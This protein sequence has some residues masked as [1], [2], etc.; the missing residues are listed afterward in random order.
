MYNG[1][2]ND[3]V[4]WR[5]FGPKFPLIVLYRVGHVVAFIGEMYGVLSWK[6]LACAL[7]QVF[8][9]TEDTSET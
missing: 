5:P 1:G 8:S 3:Q 4:A 9:R 6:S 2:G 7:E